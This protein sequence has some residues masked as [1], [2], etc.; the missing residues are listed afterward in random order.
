MRFTKVRPSERD[1]L[2]GSF[3]SLISAAAEGTREVFLGCFSSKVAKGSMTDNRET[4]QGN[5]GSIKMSPRALIW[6]QLQCDECFSKW[7]RFVLLYAS[8]ER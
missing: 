4:S 7:N 6:Y 1:V 8:A 5:K 2:R 3:L